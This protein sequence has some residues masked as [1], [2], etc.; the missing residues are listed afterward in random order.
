[1][2][3]LLQVDHIERVVMDEIHFISEKERG[4]YE[5]IG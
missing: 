3:T 2:E 1:M 4:K 5:R